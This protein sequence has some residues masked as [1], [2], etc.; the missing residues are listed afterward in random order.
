MGDK[1]VSHKRKDHKIYMIMLYTLLL[2][3]LF[4]TGCKE[5]TEEAVS[6]DLS[7]LEESQN[8]L[9]YVTDTDLK[10]EVTDPEYIDLSEAGK[11]FVIE[12]GG[13]YVL[14]GEYNQTLRIHAHDEIVHLYLENVSIETA[15]GPAIE[16]ATA[17]KVILTLAE[18]SS[19]TFFDAAHYGN[20]DLNAAI[21][22]EC[23]LTINGSGALYVCGYYQDAIHTKDVLKL[24]GGQIQLKAKRY[25]IKGNDGIVLNPDT[26]VIESEKNGCQTSNADKEGKG[27]L[28][29]RGGNISIVAGEYG[30]SS[31]SHVYIRDGE[32]YINSVIADIYAEGQQYIAEGVMVNE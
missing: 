21:S 3:L 14:T 17:G 25:G 23:D 29:I 4:L 13:E 16:I 15:T 5:V 22:S 27:I 11:D 26:L 31:V 30:L 1:S 2:L 7:V 12:H 8:E 10:T 19:N 6:T 9:L 32:V 28:D 20:K 24:L 18:G